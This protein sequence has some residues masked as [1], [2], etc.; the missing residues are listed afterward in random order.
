MKS[1]SLLDS[2]KFAWE[3]LSYSIK[4][5]RN[6]RIHL[7]AGSIAIIL[8]FLLDFSLV[9]IAML[10]M[11]IFFVVVCEIINTSIEL[12]IDFLN[13]KGHH[14]SVKMVKDIVAAGVLLAAI[15]AIIVGC[16]LFSRHI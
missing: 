3:G 10:S 6:M 13:K 16:I 4:T 12:S 8:A 15:N 14:P 5:Q 7:I 11:S 2:F 1:R 9:E